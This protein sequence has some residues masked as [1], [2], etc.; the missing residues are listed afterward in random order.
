MPMGLTLDETPY[1]VPGVDTTKYNLGNTR[2]RRRFDAMN[3]AFESIYSPVF[4]A[5]QWQ[6]GQAGTKWENEWQLARGNVKNPELRYADL[7]NPKTDAGLS[8]DNKNFG[9]NLPSMAEPDYQR[10]AEDL[11]VVMAMQENDGAGYNDGWGDPE[12]DYKGAY[13]FSENDWAHWSGKLYGEPVKGTPNPDVQDAVAVHKFMTHL[14]EYNGDIGAVAAEHYAGIPAKI[15]FYDK[16]IDFTWGT[17]NSKH[18]TM[19]EYVSYINRSY[20]NYLNTKHDTGEGSVVKGEALPSV[21]GSNYAR[22]QDERKANEF[23][24]VNFLYKNR[25]TRK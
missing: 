12:I 25:G 11:A 10:Q 1:E 7:P 2:T 19:M 6:L 17:P 9:R 5:P 15:R 18:P 8:R 21:T 13:Q 22:T 3:E 24:D 16:G 4:Y 14:K 23:P 20:L